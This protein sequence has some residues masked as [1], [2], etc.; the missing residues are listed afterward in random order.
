MKIQR[1][2]EQ[3]HNNDEMRDSLRPEIRDSW[4]RSMQYGVDPWLRSN[5]QVLSDDD[6]R[7]AIER[8]SMMIDVAL[9]V[10]DSIHD[11]VS[12]TGFIVVLTDANQCILKMVGDSSTILQAK[13][14]SCV[15]GSIWSEELAG[16]N[17][18]AL[19][20][21]LARPMSVIGYEHFAFLATIITS[22]FAPIID[23][24]KIIGSLG[25]ISSN[26]NISKQL[27]GQVVAS[28]M[29]IRSLMTLQRN[30]RYHDL[31][32]ES[33]GE[34]VMIVGINGVITYINTFGA[35]IL[36]QEKVSLIG[37]SI[38][39]L[40][41]NRQ[42]NQE[43]I[44]MVT[45]RRAVIDETAVFYIGGQRIQCNISSNPIND[46]DHS[47]AGILMI[48]RESQR[49]RKL[50]R[51]CI[52]GA[53]KMTFD[54]VIGINPKFSQAIKVAKA[55]SSSGSNVLLLGES[56]T[57]KDIIAQAIH[58]ASSR[59]SNP[60]L[61]INCA[62]LPRELIASELFGYEEGAF[63]GAKKGGNIGKFELAD[64][65]TIFLD[66]IGDMPLDLQSSLLRVLEEKSLIRLGG[67]KV[68][69]INVRIIAATNKSLD[70]EMARNRFRRD[71]YYRL[72]VIRITIPPLRERPED[73]A[74]LARHL[75]DAICQRFGRGP[76]QLDPMVIDTFLKYPWHGNV[77]EM[78]NVLEG[79]IQMTTGDLVTFDLVQEYFSPSDTP[80][81]ETFN[82][83]PTEIMT[84][85]AVEKKMIQNYL[86]KYKHNKTETAR[87]L[88][89]SRRTLYRRLKEYNLL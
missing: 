8:S 74:L 87:A 80:L 70:Y 86:D 52:G 33:M 43:I 17:G 64:Q 68:T 65:G 29:H 20:I 85:S 57:G 10:M 82:R 22:C 66:E 7:H 76:M 15:E 23:Q 49:I 84:I 78:Q 28:A 45:Q 38:Y 48:I 12:D 4:E 31:I 60:F 83:T 37:C 55:A 36:Q 54:D 6:F 40:L 32:M 71:L 53:A 3:L 56:G 61:A 25:V 42:E 19:S 62:A 21:N 50:V 79:A 51:N 5:S 24:D 9:P 47:D 88:G 14:A 39:D 77:R 67:N 26:H 2:W 81:T 16:T 1:R 30:S 89:M 73:V 27:L 46:T 63:T 58:N 59:R 41:G 11:F 69:P 44:N 72:G 13:Q 35:G 18:C 75:S 34:G